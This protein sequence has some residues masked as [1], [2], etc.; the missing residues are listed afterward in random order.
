VD[1]DKGDIARGE[2]PTTGAPHFSSQFSGFRDKPRS[3]FGCCEF[4]MKVVVQILDPPFI[5]LSNAEFWVN[6]GP[7]CRVGKWRTT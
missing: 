4:L 1:V 3:R 5:S 7:V 6:K 2:T